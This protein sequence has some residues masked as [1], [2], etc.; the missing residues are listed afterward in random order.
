VAH[1]IV[2]R[3]PG[4][5]LTDLN[6]TVFDTA[7][8]K[9]RR[10]EEQFDVAIPA[11][12]CKTPFIRQ[13]CESSEFQE[14]NLRR[15]QAEQL[16]V[17]AYQT[18]VG[19]LWRDNPQ[20]AIREIQPV[21]GALEN[22]A[23]L[24]ALGVSTIAATT[25]DVEDVATMLGLLKSWQ[26]LDCFEDFVP[27]SRGS[28]AP[29]A[30]QYGVVVALDDEQH[31]LR[32][33]PVPYRYW[34]DRKNGVEG[35]HRRNL[36]ITAWDNAGEYF[37]HRVLRHIDEATYE[38]PPSTVVPMPRRE[39]RSAGLIERFDRITAEHEVPYAV[40]RTA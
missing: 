11:Y 21:P 35:L 37:A 40:L 34:L 38:A 2:S 29:V 4:S 14:T 28:K 30:R 12:F 32:D 10:V 9:A 23:L 27:V 19:N 6:D 3:I 8:Y 20:R 36:R 16:S 1:P 22:L 17:P 24:R 26:A 5:F 18:L 33:L 31:K 7:P 13:L 39:I 15:P 25:R